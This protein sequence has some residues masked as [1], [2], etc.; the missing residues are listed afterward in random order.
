MSNYL[1]GFSV[2]N[3]RYDYL[4]LPPRNTTIQSTGR[5]ELRLNGNNASFYYVTTDNYGLTAVISCC[6]VIAAD[7]IVCIAICVSKR[8]KTVIRL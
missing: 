1:D 4:P 7:I 5:Y 2:Y 8:E 6:A 3:L